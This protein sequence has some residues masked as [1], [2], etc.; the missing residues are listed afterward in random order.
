MYRNASLYDRLDQADDFE[1]FSF[2]IG[3]VELSCDFELQGY[4]LWQNYYVAKEG[5]DTYYS[6]KFAA[7]KIKGN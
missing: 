6:V 5:E 3:G 7:K 4:T 1:D 2:V